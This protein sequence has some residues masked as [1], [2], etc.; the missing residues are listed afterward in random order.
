[1][2]IFTNN[3]ILILIA[4][5]VAV[6]GVAI[7]IGILIQNHNSPFQVQQEES[8]QQTESNNDV[9]L[10]EE[11]N[12]LEDGDEFFIENKNG[13]LLEG[14]SEDYQTM[15]D[16]KAGYF[17]K[18]PSEMKAKEGGFESEFLYISINREKLSNIS[19]GYRYLGYDKEEILKDKESLE[20]GEFGFKYP[21]SSNRKVVEIDGQIYGKEFS[22]IGMF[23]ICDVQ[24]GSTL[25]FFKNDYKVEINV[26][27]KYELLNDM[28]AQ[29]PEYFTTN[30][31]NCGDK[32]IWPENSTF[33]EDLEN[34]IIRKETIAGSWYYM[35]NELVSSINLYL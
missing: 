7:G 23:E 18:I 21:F 32:L 14:K 1:M 5:F 12:A 30:E 17:L 4:V 6:F 15:S 31:E 33:F 22:T 28:S 27:V 35:F 34:G 19:E 26:G 11:D 13:Y 3:K 10:Q 9:N 16:Q 8:L 29:I 25:I 20:N 2:Y 24:A